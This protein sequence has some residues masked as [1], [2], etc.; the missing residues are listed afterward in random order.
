MMG[1]VWMIMGNFQSRMMSVSPRHQ[2]IAG[3]LGEL[4]ISNPN[5]SSIQSCCRAR[6]SWGSGRCRRLL[7][8]YGT[9]G[10]VIVFTAMILAWRRLAGCAALVSRSFLRR[11]LGADA[12]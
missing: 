2:K 6:R 4:R 11:L 3:D 10:V 5:R 1:F 12:G 8:K 9:F 7:R